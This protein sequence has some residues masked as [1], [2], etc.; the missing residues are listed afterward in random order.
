MT[1]DF[2]KGIEGLTDEAIEK[3]IAENGKDI[4]KAQGNLETVKTELKEAKETISSIT[5]EL[6][7]LKESNASVEDY[8]KKFEDLQATVSEKERVEKEKAAAAERE[9][10]LKARY[11]A[12]CVGK[13]GNP[14]EWAH[15]AIGKE[16]FAKF[17]AAVEDK[18]NI[19]KSDADIFHNLV[20]DDATAFKGVQTVTLAGGKPL[21]SRGISKEDFMKM[22]YAE[23]LKV[24]TEQPELYRAITES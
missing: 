7:N 22:G 8:K 21:D 18:E 9:A 4:Q 10:N 3:I 15:E 6:N 19:G 5:T 23:R 13:D 2:L 16:Y 14:L 24:K 1:R 20:K 17:M 12:V 11:A